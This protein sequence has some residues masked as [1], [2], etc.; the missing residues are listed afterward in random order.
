MRTIAT[1]ERYWEDSIGR[2]WRA[3]LVETDNPQDREL[4]GERGLTLGETFE[5]AWSY[6]T[7]LNRRRRD[8]GHPPIDFI[9][10]FSR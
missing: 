1:I 10:I 4:F 6:A 3:V 7:A 9:G 2:V 5:E 8:Q